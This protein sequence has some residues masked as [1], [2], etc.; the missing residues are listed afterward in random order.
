MVHAGLV[1]AEMWKPG[2]KDEYVTVYAF[3]K[4]GTLRLALGAWKGSVPSA[5]HA[6]LGSSQSFWCWVAERVVAKGQA[7]EN[8][9]SVRAK[10]SGG[11][12][13]STSLNPVTNAQIVCR[14]L[15]DKKNKQAH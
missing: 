3:L 11:D 8:V 15:L 14:L 6:E 13:K 2:D 12:R 5:A 9:E 10:F 1:P 7:V 4:S